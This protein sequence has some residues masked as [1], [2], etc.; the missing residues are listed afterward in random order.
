MN[1][2]KRA[3]KLI[4]NAMKTLTR[5]PSKEDDETA[6]KGSKSS[7]KIFTDEEEITSSNKRTEE[8]I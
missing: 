6:S 2:S 5:T 8:S 4:T 3:S 1:M 7:L